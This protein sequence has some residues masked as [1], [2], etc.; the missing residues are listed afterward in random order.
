MLGVVV[1]VYSI[2]Q[3]ARGLG[4]A[5]RPLPNA[6]PGEPERYIPQG[7]EIETG[8]IPMIGVDALGPEERDLWE[9]PGGNVIRALSLV[10]DEVRALKDLSA[11]HYLTPQEMMD[12]TKGRAIDRRQMELVAG[13]VSA[14]NECFY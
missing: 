6:L 7:L 1:T 14:L 11:A 8:W 3:F 12:L 4:L 5:P 13:R 10:P 2:D 9:P